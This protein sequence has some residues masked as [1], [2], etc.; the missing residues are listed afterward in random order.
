MPDQRSFQFPEQLVGQKAVNDISVLRR[1][2]QAPACVK[3]LRALGIFLLLGLVT[4]PARSED[5]IF[6]TPSR[7]P[8]PRWVML[9]RNEV[10]ARS[11]PSKD[12]AKVWTYRVAKL[13]VQIISETKDWR[14][15]CDP[16]G[17]VAWV[18]RT[19]LQNAGTVMS[20]ANQ[21][22]SMYASPKIDSDVRA[23]L[24]PKAI[25]QLE[26]CKKDWCRINADGVSG[27]VPKKNLWG[28]QDEP[29]CVRPDPFADK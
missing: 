13:P 20:P 24:R 1:L 21:K 6:D 17:N 15:I 19:M 26:K 3:G 11:G 28:T 18:S 10:Y 27:W 4:A 2:F 5:A 29:A 16:D 14:L 23:V 9:R 25:A 8:V 12:N 7:S 22:L